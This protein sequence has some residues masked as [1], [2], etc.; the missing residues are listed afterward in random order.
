MEI[1]VLS[2]SH[3]APPAQSLAPF[4]IRG[5]ATRREFNSRQHILHYY[6]KK[7]S[8]S[9]IV[10]ASSA[11]RYTMEEV[12]LQININGEIIHI[13]I[14]PFF[15]YDGLSIGVFQFLASRQSRLAGL[16]HDFIYYSGRFDRETCDAIMKA[17]QLFRGNNILTT[18]IY[19]IG[20]RLGG[21][22]SYQQYRLK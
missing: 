4:F 11:V 21:K 8:A 1:E 20:V 19:H 6:N 17:V 9:D 13:D 14:P 18:E 3:N 10:R 2:T 22:S 7:I 5:V 16:V 15:I 12:N